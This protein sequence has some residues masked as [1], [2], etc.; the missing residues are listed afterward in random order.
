MKNKMKVKTTAIVHRMLTAFLAIAMSPLC[1]SIAF[2]E[3]SSVTVPEKTYTNPLTLNVA[4]D[5]TLAEAL[6]AAGATVANLTGNVYDKVVKTGVGKVTVDTDIAAFAGDLFVSNGTWCITVNNGWG[7]A[8]DPANNTSFIVIADGATL[9]IG[10]S[11]KISGLDKTIYASGSGYGEAGAVCVS[12]STTPDSDGC[13]SWGR[14]IVLTGD[15]TFAKETSATGKLGRNREAQMTTVYLQGHKLTF[16][17][18]GESLDTCAYWAT[19]GKVEITSGVLAMSASGKYSKFEGDSSS[20]LILSGTGRLKFGGGYGN[21]NSAWTLVVRNRTPLTWTGSPTE[22]ANPDNA[23][24]PGPTRLETDTLLTGKN[25]TSF[26]LNGA[27]TGAYSLAYASVTAGKTPH[28]YLN[29]VSNDFTGGLVVTDAVLHAAANGSIPTAGGALDLTRATVNLAKVSN[30]T[31]PAVLLRGACTLSPA[32]AKFV[33][34]QATPGLYEGYDDQIATAAGATSD[35]TTLY[36]D[37]IQLSPRWANTQTNITPQDAVHFGRWTYS[38]YIWNTNAEPVVWIFTASPRYRGVLRVGEAWVN[39][40]AGTGSTDTS[41]LVSSGKRGLIR[42]TLQP[43]ANRIEFIGM[44]TATNDMKTGSIGLDAPDSG[45]GFGKHD[46]LMVYKQ[47][48]TLDVAKTISKDNGWEKLSDPGDG[49]VF[50]I[51]LPPAPVLQTIF[52][53]A[54][55]FGEES[56]LELAGW[57]LVTTNLFGF[58]TITNGTATAA[59]EESALTVEGSWTIDGAAVRAGG[60]LVT[61]RAVV[62]G[63]AATVVLTDKKKASAGKDYVIL[64]AEGGITGLPTC[65]GAKL[66]LSPDGKSLVY[67]RNAVGMVVVFH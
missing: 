35:T 33:D 41:L 34:R 39:T 16:Q 47:D 32:A 56:T 45:L 60:K 62:F 15:A 13:G 14:N 55:S 46:A 9:E 67:C 50:T 24:W 20:E 61:D 11:D 2:G 40:Q 10:G 29:S 36:T 52:V 6:A 54:L 58:G 63:P 4:S 44:M 18:N 59:S 28:L 43:G 53:P 17:L 7:E 42:A 3:F 5:Q 26:T 51:D 66:K 19:G 27:V 48:V 57:S 25:G 22:G 31:L 30:Y 21:P 1:A 65:E 12:N 37:S 49:S 8:S 23:F 38:G 64:T